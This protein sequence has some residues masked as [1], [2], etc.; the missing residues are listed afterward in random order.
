MENNSQDVYEKGEWLIRVF[1][2][3]NTC[4][5]IQWSNSIH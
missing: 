2:E 4:Q 5:P 1:K 3:N